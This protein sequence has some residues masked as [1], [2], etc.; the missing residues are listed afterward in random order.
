M[1]QNN[2]ESPIKSELSSIDKKEELRTLFVSGLPLDV[3]QREFNLLFHEFQGYEGAIIKPPSR[4]TKTQQGMIQQPQG[5]VAFLTFSTRKD[6]ELAKEKFQGFQLDPD[7][8]HI[9][10]KLE[11]AKANTKSRY[12][13]RDNQNNGQS[14]FFGDGNQMLHALPL[15]SIQQQFTTPLAIDPS[16]FMQ[17]DICGRNMC[18]PMC[19]SMPYPGPDQTLSYAEGFSPLQMDSNGNITALQPILFP[20]DQFPALQHDARRGFE[21]SLLA[22]LDQSL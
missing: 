19:W 8:P 3:K 17:G 18:W 2:N 5:P 21:E 9:S 13:S 20:S 11:F 22:K 15:S 4:L 10:L 12:R 14:Q 7:A 6:A 16:A 1:D